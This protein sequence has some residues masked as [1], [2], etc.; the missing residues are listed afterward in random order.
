VSLFFIFERTMG[1]GS[2]NM[3]YGDVVIVM[4]IGRNNME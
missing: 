2:C 1:V 3:E 4:Y